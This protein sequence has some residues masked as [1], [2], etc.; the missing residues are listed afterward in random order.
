MK[1]TTANLKTLQKDL[2]L[3]VITELPLTLDEINSKLGN[4]NFGCPD[5]LLRILNV[6]R[7]KGLIN[8]EF[9]K[10]SGKWV[11]WKP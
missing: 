6:L 9:S 3:Q 11:W 7:K 1:E 5:D 2:L 8:G 10:S 4:I